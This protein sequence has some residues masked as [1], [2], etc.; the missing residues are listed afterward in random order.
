MF[1]SLSAL[2]RLFRHSSDAMVVCRLHNLS[3]Q[4]D[5]ELGFLNHSALTLLNLSTSPAPKTPLVHI[6]P[7]GVLYTHIHAACQT[8]ES[9]RGCLMQLNKLLAYEINRFGDWLVIRLE[10]SD[11]AS[12]FQKALGNHIL[13]TNHVAVTLLDPVF[14]ESNQIRDFQLVAH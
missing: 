14:D 5:V 6:L 11:S 4:S 1:N 13:T 8:E 12:V 3:D 2:E 7:D 9:V 10:E